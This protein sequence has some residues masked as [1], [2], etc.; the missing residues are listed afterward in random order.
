MT[1]L[2]TWAHLDERSRTAALERPWSAAAATIASEVRDIVARVKEHGDAALRD[3][4]R[5]FDGVELESFEVTP[6]E[7]AR[8]EH[9]LDG[10]QRQAI[11]VAIRN[12]SSFHR[13]QRSATVRVEIEPG[14]VCEQRILPIGRV[15]LY[16]PAGSAPLPSTAVMLGVPAS[17][18]GCPVRILCTPPSSNGSVNPAVLVA[19][20][21]AG[22]QR[23][24]K[25][26]GAQA[27]AAMAYGTE[28]VPKCDKVFGPGNAWVT[29]AK[30]H[31]AV[32]PEGAA[33]DLPAGPSEVMVIA[34][35]QAR[36]E[37]VAADLLAQSE[38]SI[39][40]QALLVTDSGALAA[41]VEME[42][43]AQR[44]G[45]SR[46]AILSRALEHLRIIVA[47]SIEEALEVANR[48]A[49]E[50]LILQVRTPR[51]WLEQV[52]CAGSVFL[53]P[54]TPESVG[55]YCSGTNHTL[56]TAG[57]ARAHSALS[58]QDFQRRMSVQ[59]LS[60]AGLRALGDTTCTLAAME[61][62]DGHAAAVRRRLRHSGAVLT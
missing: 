40:A 4:T 54:W 13:A 36:A 47:A 60:E 12:V 34:D 5:T 43:Q 10:G 55:D 16:V 8:A 39:D 61:G 7:F 6:E 42:I 41:A 29:A 31:V 62:L 57:H 23:I 51:R 15:G 24:F 21:L 49:P 32:D 59:E 11:T 58:L 14:V 45:L 46:S 9:A 17:I 35:A 48:Y 44:A 30:L 25:L 33:L 19:A 37:W 50:H 1:Q 28:S 52:R 22:V 27:I 53:G 38:H 26:G 18:A 3:F 20:K 2:I 56:P